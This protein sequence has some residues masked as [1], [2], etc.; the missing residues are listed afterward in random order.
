MLQENELTG[1]CFQRFFEFFQ[2]SSSVSINR[3]KQGDSN[4]SHFMPRVQECFVHQFP[5]IAA[6]LSLSELG[7]LALSSSNLLCAVENV[8]K[9]VNQSVNIDVPIVKCRTLRFV[10]VAI[11]IYVDEH[12]NYVVT[13]F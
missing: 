2:T 3:I 6:S 8:K 11:A 5:S 10:M 9:I 1:E 12:I 7:P 4:M 13:V